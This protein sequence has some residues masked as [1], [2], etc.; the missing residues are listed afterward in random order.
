MRLFPSMDVIRH[1]ICLRTMFFRKICRDFANK[2]LPQPSIFG[3]FEEFGFMSSVD[4]WY[5]SRLVQDLAQVS[6]C[7]VNKVLHCKCRAGKEHEFLVFEILSPAGDCT[8][9]VVLTDSLRFSDSSRN[10]SVASH[11]LS[12]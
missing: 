5:Q 10:K 8:S 3:L 11:H 4:V 12:P 6:Q 1:E 9:F 2:P 7:F